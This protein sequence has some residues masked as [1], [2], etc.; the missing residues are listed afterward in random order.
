[1]GGATRFEEAACELSLTTVSRACS[2]TN[3]PADVPVS[4]AGVVYVAG[5]GCA[6]SDP[7]TCVYRF[8]FPHHGREPSGLGLHTG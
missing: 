3:L 8:L 4:L 6:L 7:M 5:T 2:F 1:M